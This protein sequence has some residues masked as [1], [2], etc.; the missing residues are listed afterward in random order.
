MHEMLKRKYK[1]PKVMMQQWYYNKAKATI[2]FRA[3][4]ILFANQKKNCM[5][6]SNR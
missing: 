3:K 5:S 6:S 2:H 1:E 4:K